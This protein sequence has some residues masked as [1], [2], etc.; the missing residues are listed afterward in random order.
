[1]EQTIVLPI[2]LG[3]RAFAVTRK[4]NYEQGG[5]E[6]LKIKNITITE[7]T[8]FRNGT[9]RHYISGNHKYLPVNVCAT[10]EEAEVRIVEVSKE[11]AHLF[12][13]SI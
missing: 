9:V 3:S 12:H 11:L 4:F 5:L 8:L 13:R 7:V 2:A 10:R 6:Q 1:M